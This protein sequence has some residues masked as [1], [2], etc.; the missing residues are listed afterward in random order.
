M[1][2][3]GVLTN[4]TEE[5]LLICGLDNYELSRKSPRILTNF[6][7]SRKSL[8]LFPFQERVSF[9]KRKY[10]F[11]SKHLNIVTKPPPGLTLQKILGGFDVFFVTWDGGGFVFFVISRYK[12]YFFPP[13]SRFKLGS[14]QTVI[15]QGYRWSSNQPNQYTVGVSSDLWLDLP[16]VW[17]RTKLTY[18]DMSGLS[19]K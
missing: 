9:L 12:K 18:G 3:V 4:P 10:F 2:T 1:D 8:N 17:I 5:C 15:I 19:G 7:V 14:N 6:S 11:L 16:V 13:P